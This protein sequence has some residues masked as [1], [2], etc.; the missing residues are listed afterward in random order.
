MTSLGQTAASVRSRGTQ[1][2]AAA[3]PGLHDQAGSVPIHDTR[4]ATFAPNRGSSLNYSGKLGKE[5]DNRHGTIYTPAG[6]SY[7][8]GKSE[9]KVIALVTVI[10]FFVRMYKISQP[11]SVV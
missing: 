7:K 1:G 2:G 11:S 10:A 6:S 8:L 4:Q 3:A 9:G 5:Q